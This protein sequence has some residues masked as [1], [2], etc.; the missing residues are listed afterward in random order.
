MRDI[1]EACGDVLR[2]SVPPIIH[3]PSVLFN[4]KD[5]SIFPV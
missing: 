4:S 2:A 1:V 5:K 3:G